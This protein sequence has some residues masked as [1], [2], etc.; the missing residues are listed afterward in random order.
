[1]QPVAVPFPLPEYYATRTHVAM[2]ASS[3][4]QRGNS[5]LKG[6]DRDLK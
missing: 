2:Q 6:A 5:R 4:V 3:H 1:M